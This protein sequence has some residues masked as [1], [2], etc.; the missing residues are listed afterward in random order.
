MV[1]KFISGEWSQASIITC[2]AEHMREKLVDLGAKQE[3]I[4]VVMFGIDKEI[5]FLNRPPFNKQKDNKKFVVGSIR[6][7]HPV[8]DVITFLK[9]AKIVLNKRQDV[10]F[11]VAGSGPDLQNLKSFVDENELNSHINFIGRLEALQ[12]PNF[13]NSLDIYSTP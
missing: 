1:Q 5:F 13:Y 11:S 8:Y 9:A 4:R 3:S 12:L 10:I 6:N 2:D 7:L